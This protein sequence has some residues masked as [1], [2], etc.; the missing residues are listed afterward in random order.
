MDETWP[1]Y[2]NAGGVRQPQGNTGNMQQQQQQRDTRNASSH[3]TLPSVGGSYEAYHA[4]TSS[5]YTQ[6]S[7]MATSRSRAYSVD[8]DVSMEDADPY[9]RTKYPS[10]ASH[11][12]RPSGHYLAN[13]DSSAAR[14][15]SPMKALSPGGQYSTPQTPHQSGYNSYTTPDVSARQS[16]VRS[17]HY[18]TPSQTYPATPNGPLASPG[19]VE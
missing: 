5:A 8:Q 14:R 15:Y 1:N 17:N 4:P 10:R 13:E 16:P 7:P 6:G 19:K 2:P 9:N 11:Q 18:A 3:R 12:R